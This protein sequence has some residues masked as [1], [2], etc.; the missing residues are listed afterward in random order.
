M[1]SEA[2]TIPSAWKN[3]AALTKPN[4][5]TETFDA[6]AA[7]AV[8]ADNVSL[9]L[10]VGPSVTLPSGPVKKYWYKNVG[11]KVSTKCKY[12]IFGNKLFWMDKFHCEKTTIASTNPYTHIQVI[13]TTSNKRNE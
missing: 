10:E 2:G 4:P 13:V 11:F 6:V 1:I 8:A 9:A 12:V 7:Y 5:P 3:L